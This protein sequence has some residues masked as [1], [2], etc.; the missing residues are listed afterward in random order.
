[1]VEGLVD[2]L[3]LVVGRAK[4]GGDVVR[5]SVPLGPVLVA[6]DDLGGV[7]QLVGDLPQDRGLLLGAGR[8][9][10]GL[11]ECVEGGG[12]RLVWL[13]AE[14]MGVQCLGECGD[15]SAA[16]AV[17]VLGRGLSAD[18]EADDHVAGRGAGDLVG[19]SLGDVMCRGDVGRRGE[20]QEDGG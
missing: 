12:Q 14:E 8:G 4:L 16:F 13:E 17:A 6:L 11:Q 1:M 20:L 15:G 18:A 10:G 9:V 5:E 19:E 3:D 7:A 2:L